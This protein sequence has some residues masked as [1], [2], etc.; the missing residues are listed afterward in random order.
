MSH[1]KRVAVPACR[2]VVFTAHPHRR[3]VAPTPPPR[4]PSASPGANV[5]VWRTARCELDVTSGGDIL[6]AKR[7]L[8]YV[9][10]LV[11]VEQYYQDCRHG[12]SSYSPLVLVQPG[13]YPQKNTDVCYPSV[14]KHLEQGGGGAGPELECTWVVFDVK[15]TARGGAL[16]SPALTVGACGMPPQRHTR[17]ICTYSRTT[18][19]GFLY[20]H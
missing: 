11:W 10:G 7:M 16:G 8:L 1:R 13:L 18:M 19:Q 17:I 3:F 5:S 15:C 14:Y 12:S 20:V 9:F 6:V 2:V 4:P